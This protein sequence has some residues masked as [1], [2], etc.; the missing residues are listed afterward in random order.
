[1]PEASEPSFF[2]SWNNKLLLE[3]KPV[4][5][6]CYVTANKIPYNTELVPS[7]VPCLLRRQ[8]VSSLILP[9]K[10]TSD[11][12]GSDLDQQNTYD[13][14]VSSDPNW[15]ADINAELWQVAYIIW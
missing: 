1:M 12:I 3:F 11:F 10:R 15:E 2:D 9:A 7:P 8:V 4:W 14:N 6:G 13:K 5:V